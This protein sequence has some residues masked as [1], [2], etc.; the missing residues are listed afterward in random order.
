MAAFDFFGG[1]P[2]SILYDNTKLAVAKI[3]GDGKRTR[4]ETFTALQ[5]H[6]LFD[7]RFGRPGK[8]IDERLAADLAAFHALPAVPFD[9]CD[10]RTS[11]V[12]PS[13]LDIDTLDPRVVGQGA[14]AFRIGGHCVP[15]LATGID[16][17]VIVDEHSVGEE[18]FSQEQ[19]DPFDRVEFRA[20][21]RKGNRRD[22]GGHD[23][24]FGAVPSGLVHDEQD[25]D[26]RVTVGGELFE[27]TVHGFGVGFWHDQREVFARRWANGREDIG[28]L[29]ATVAETER[30]L[31]PDPPAMSDP[32]LLAESPLILEPYFNALTLMKKCCLHQ[33]RF[34][35]PFLKAS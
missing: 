32:S 22:V 10:K 2:L 8:G 7:D 19:P 11:R 24:V 35:P 20:V 34:E 30:A 3:L 6:Y 26:V 14:E 28:G 17:G 25:M 12:I 15:G 29:E 4:T 9:P 5:S 1:R 16:D 21:G 31:P 27:E 13:S 18:A 23:E 33:G